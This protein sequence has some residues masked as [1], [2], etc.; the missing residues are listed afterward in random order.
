MKDALKSGQDNDAVAAIVIIDHSEL[1][2]AIALLYNSWL[3]MS[4]IHGYDSAIQ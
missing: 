4:S 2:I 3:Q 1:D